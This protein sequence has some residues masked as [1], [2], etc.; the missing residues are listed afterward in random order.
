MRYGIETEYPRPYSAEQT[1]EGAAAYLDMLRRDPSLAAMESL[2]YWHVTDPDEHRDNPGMV[3]ALAH[4]LSE[5][6]IHTYPNP[7]AGA[8][9]IATHYPLKV[10][11]AEIA[12]EDIRN[13]TLDVFAAFNQQGE[14]VAATSIVYNRDLAGKVYAEL[15]RTGVDKR[16][17][18]DYSARGLMKKRLEQLLSSPNYRNRLCVEGEEIE[19]MTSEL[20]TADDW[21]GY[22]PGGKGVHSVFFGGSQYEGQDL[23]FAM[24]GVSRKYNL[25]R[26]EPFTNVM[27]PLDP[28]AYAKAM[29]SYSIVVPSDTV[30]NR[31]HALMEEG[32]GTTPQFIVATAPELTA[33]PED[34]LVISSYDPTAS[35][36]KDIGAKISVIEVDP[37]AMEALLM[38]DPATRPQT[39]SLRDALKASLQGGAPYIEVHVDAVVGEQEGDLDRTVGVMNTLR[40][41]GF[42]CTG[43]A[44]STN[45]QTARPVLTFGAM[46]NKPA[47]GLAQP[48]YP[49]RYYAN[50]RPRSRQAALDIFDDL[51]SNEL[52]F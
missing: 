10:S 25:G 39:A 2:G 8:D 50:G 34:I 21:K 11:N 5:V 13:G 35:H 12:A 1:E 52:R 48:N 29:A 27:R 36:A 15:G 4:G 14:V 24:T 3:S 41:M 38:Q 18:S 31:L 9:E 28:E 17:T 42:V 16:K 7:E 47:L 26:N 33:P 37:H 32:F 6:V 40:S 20:R 30:R 45:G 44:P 43:W 49:E 51:N 46:A 22:F 19:Y 23:G